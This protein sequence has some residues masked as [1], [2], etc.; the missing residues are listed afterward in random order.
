MPLDPAA[1]R[2]TF[3]VFMLSPLSSSVSS[4]PISRRESLRVLGLGALALASS[5][6]LSSISR[7]ADTEPSLKGHEPGY[8]RFQIGEIEAIA[9][10]DGGLDSPLSK[11]KWWAGVPD[12]EVSDALLAAFESPSEIRLSFTVLLLK[13][14]NDL[15]LVDSGCGPLFGP[16]GGWLKTSLAQVNISPDQITGLILSHAHG[17]HMGGLLDTNHQPVFKNARLFINEAE[18][19]FWMQENPD[20]S[21]VKM[22]EEAKVAAVKNAKLYLST[23]KSKWNF[24]KEGD[25][26]F[27]G[28][29]VVNAFGHTPGHTALLIGEGDTRLLHIA[30]AAHHHTL[31]FEH[32][33][34]KFVADVLPDVAVETRRRLLDRAAKER[35]TI[36]GAHLPFP[37]LGH[38]R[39]STGHFE[40]EIQPWIVG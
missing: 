36:F 11:M 30:D 4:H 7:A 18:Y 10:T 37:A 15:V 12:K 32:P 35:L 26:P 1:D 40:Y 16:I 27:R 25:K 22:P 34:W 2:K 17:D 31:S 33:D 29:E 19:K 14:G 38:V 21:A 5:P 6:L 13:L 28:V 9:L 20:M 24:V 23:L 3:A 8:Y 39:E